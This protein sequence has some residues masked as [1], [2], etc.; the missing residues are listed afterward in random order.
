MAVFRRGV[1]ART[2]ALAGALLLASV[3]PVVAQKAGGTLR[4]YNTTQPPSASIH[5]ESTIATNMPFMAIFNNLVLSIR[6]DRATVLTASCP[7]WRSAGLGMR[8]A[9]NSPL[10]ALRRQLA[11]RQALYGQGRAVHLASPQRHRGRV[12]SAQPA[13]D[14]VR[15]PQRGDAERRPRGDLPPG[16]SRS[17]RCCRC[18]PQA[19]RRFILPRVRPRHA[20]Q[21]RSAP[22][23]SSS[24]SSRA[25]P[26]SSLFA[27]P[28][29]GKRGC[30]ISMPSTG[31]LSRAARRAFWPSSPASST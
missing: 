24:P 5:E 9:P 21:A 13:Q 28:T 11:R 25:T 1:G 15:E 3:L 27:T 17:H 16:R 14:L 29:T 6:K 26:P 30:P 8:R 22:V 4:I 20:H 7:S 2:S 12:F 23:P 31:A 18:S 10:A 19:F